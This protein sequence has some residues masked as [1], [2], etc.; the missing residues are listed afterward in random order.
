MHFCLP[1]VVFRSIAAQFNLALVQL[2]ELKS[3]D[4]DESRDIHLSPEAEHRHCA[5]PSPSRCLF[6]TTRTGK[7]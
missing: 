1:E 6:T 7:G 5:S 4:R 3:R 2:P